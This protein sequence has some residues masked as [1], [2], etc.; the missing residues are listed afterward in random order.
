MRATPR[1]LA[2]GIDRIVDDAG[3]EDKQSA[4]MAFPKNQNA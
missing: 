1:R 3:R 2:I 4:I